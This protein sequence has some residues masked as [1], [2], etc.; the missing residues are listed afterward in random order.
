MRRLA[1][2]LTVTATAVLLAAM[3]LEVAFRMAPSLLPRGIYGAGRMD[4]ELGMNVHG[5]ATIYRGARTT[6]R[7]PNADGFLDVEH[8][9]AKP[10]GVFRVGFFG[11]SFVESL[12]VRGEETFYRLLPD[13]LLPDRARDPG[14]EALGFGMSGWGT[15]HALRAYRVYAS[16]YDLDAAIYVFVE[17]DPGDNLAS[18]SGWRRIEAMPYAA[19]M[20]DPPGYAVVWNRPPGDPPRWLGLAKA[21][22]RRSRLAQL[23]LP[24]LRLL[25]RLGP[26]PSPRTEDL[27]MSGAARGFVPSQDDLPGSWPATLRGEA[28]SVAEALLEEWSRE[29]EARHHRFA[30]L[31]VPRAEAQ[32]EGRLAEAE[33][34]LP[35]LRTTCAELSIPLIDPSAAL[36]DR[37][38]EGDSLYADHWAPAGHEV[39]AGVL[40]SY[41]RSGL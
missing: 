24:R 39:V 14:L 34:W 2:N 38:A 5:A 32:L 26:R 40:A 22:Q 19:P 13:R 35:W 36:R 9:L 18:I 10:R 31:Y 29:A 3:A 12:Q 8:V 16:R 20:P 27:E 33:T 15:L 21:V 30:V 41:L 25:L 28:A 6:R 1:K 7:L 23:A 17:N 11:D 4:P 37:L